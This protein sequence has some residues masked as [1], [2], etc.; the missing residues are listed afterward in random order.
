MPK[1]SSQASHRYTAA[2]GVIS[3]KYSGLLYK[4]AQVLKL[5]EEGV[6]KF[7]SDAR[8]KQVLDNIEAAKK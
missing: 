1:S 7:S 2:A 5:I 4:D 8:A 6:K 3:E